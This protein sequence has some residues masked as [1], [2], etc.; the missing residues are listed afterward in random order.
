MPIAPYQKFSVGKMSTPILAKSLATKLDAKYILAV[1]ALDSYKARELD[2]YINLLK[3]YNIEPD[4]YWIDKDNIAKL[5]DKINYL[6]EHGYIHTKKM[7]IM[8]CNCKKVEI[9][10]ENI[11]TIN[12]TDACFY[13]KDSH[14][15]CKHCGSICTEKEIDSLVFNSKLIQDASYTFFPEFINKD[16]KTFYNTILNNEIVISRERNTGVTLTYQNRTY[17]I[18]IDFLWEVYLSLFPNHDKIVICSNHQLYQLFMVSMLEKCFEN[19]GKTIALATPYLNIASKDKESELQDRIL[20]T[21]I[22]TILNQ[23][24]AKKENI[25][26][27]GLLTYINS[28][29]VN[30]KEMLYHILM[31]RN[32]T[33]DILED[34]KKS[35]LRDFNLQN[36]NKELKRRRKNV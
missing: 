11:S 19:R 14:Y 29:N 27:E 17:N 13:E 24:W 22:F 33:I 5:L 20:S 30:K 12:M 2:E 6:I 36:A 31:D 32:V 4:E 7:P 9:P 16:I 34:L 23:K 35:L 28:M 1:N 26:D 8:S 18:D 21:K 3:Q 25:L 15:Y 10:V